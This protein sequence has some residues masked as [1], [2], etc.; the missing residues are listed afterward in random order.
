MNERYSKVAKS[1]ASGHKI[2]IRS[3]KIGK[4]RKIFHIDRIP[5]TTVLPSPESN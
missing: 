1:L 4:D 3:T 5:G 2:K